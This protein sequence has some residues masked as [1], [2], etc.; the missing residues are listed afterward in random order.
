MVNKHKSSSSKIVKPT[1]NVPSVDFLFV[2]LY[3][4]VVNQKI[5]GGDG[6]SV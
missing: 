3:R 1:K 2:D 4:P 5:I 6:G